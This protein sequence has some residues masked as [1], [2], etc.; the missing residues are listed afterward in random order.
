MRART[1]ED[2]MIPLP[3]L[4]TAF[5][6]ERARCDKT[7]LGAREIEKVAGTEHAFDWEPTLGEHRRWSQNGHKTG[8]SPRS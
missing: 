8:A 6:C 3:R 7:A 1:H 4:N 2:H 5:L